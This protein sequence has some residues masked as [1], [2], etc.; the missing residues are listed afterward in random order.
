MGG[1]FGG[2]K[3]Q[4]S[5]PTR[6]NAMQ[7]NQSAY[8]NVVP[9]L[10][11]TDRLQITLIDYQDFNSKAT[12]SQSSSGKGGSGQTTSGYTYSASWVGLLC[13]GPVTGILQVYADQTQ[14]TLAT[15]PGGPL[16]LF[17][18]TSGQAPWSYMTTNHPTHAQ[19]YDGKAYIAAPN[20]SLGSGA[21]MPN[22]TFEVQGLKLYNGGPDA[23]PF[24]IN[25][26]Y[27]TDPNHGV[28]FPYLDIP[29]MQAANGWRDYC[30]AMGFL[31]S[32]SET[33]Q[34]SAASFIGEL[35]QATNS[36][37]VW[38][39]GIGL[40]IVPYGD[41]V[42][43]GNGVTY[44]PNLTPEFA[45]IDDDYCPASGS[46][47][48]QVSITPANQTYNI[49][50]VEFL[51]RT[52]QYNT[53]IETY[54]DEQDIA[55]NG[56]RI[57]PT[58]NLHCIKI[59]AIAAVVAALA[60][61]RNLYI[62][63]IYTFTVRMDY[64]LLEPMDFVSITETQTGIKNKLLR[65]TETTDN[66]DDSFTIVAEEMLV[67]PAHA[68]IY[69]TQFAAGYAANYGA[70]PGNVDVPY[71][72]TF[73]PLLASPGSGGY[74]LGIAVGGTSGMWGG[75]DIYASLDNVTYQR[76]GSNTFAAQYG[77]L[78]GPI[79]SAPDPDTV[80]VLSVQLNSTIQDPLVSLSRA[81]ADNLR[82]PML[83]DG[84]IMSYQTATPLGNDAFKLNYLRR[85][86]YGSANTSHTSSGQFA[87][88]NDGIFRLPFDPGLVGQP[89]WFKFQ[90]YNLFGGGVQDLSTL[91]AYAATFQGQNGGQ[92]T[93]PGATPLIARGQCVIQGNSIYKQPGSASQWDSDCYSKDAFAGGCSMRFQSCQLGNTGYSLMIGLNSDPLTDQNYTSLDHAWYINNTDAKAYIYRN[94][95]FIQSTTTFTTDTVFEIRYDGKFVK[96]YQDSVLWYTVAD[97]NK[98]FFLDSSFYTPGAAVQN[99]FFGSLNPANSTP[100]IT[101]GGCTV[102]DESATKSGGVDA[103]Y[104]SDMYSLEGYPTMHFSCKA[105]QTNAFMMI[106]ITE[107]PGG[108]QTYND[109]KW[110]WYFTSSGTCQELIRPS[111]GGNPVLIGTPVAYDKTTVFGVTYDGTTISPTINGVVVDPHA[112]FSTSNQVYFLHVVFFN[113]G[114]G[115]NTLQYG[116]STSN[117]IADTAQ[118]GANS[119]SGL[120]GVTSTSGGSGTILTSSGTSFAQTFVAGSTA[121]NWGSPYGIDMQVD[122]QFRA[123]TGSPTATTLGLSAMSLQMMRDGGAG[124]ATYVP[125]GAP[126]D[127][128]AVL[129]GVAMTQVAGQGCYAARQLVTLST[130]DVLPAHPVGYTYG[131]FINWTASGTAGVVA[132]DWIVA[133]N[134]CKIREYKR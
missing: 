70:D 79:T 44:T 15:A 96:Y 41:Q 105:N 49:W 24:D 30:T 110:G 115:F 52:N 47:P 74:E 111:T 28:G 118:L 53:A 81:D 25:V 1:L 82:Q 69:N 80:N 11:G 6:F 48:I 90:S 107:S 59:R 83:V 33:T 2:K 8:G 64:S 117:Q 55:I 75:C 66:P 95:N 63:A 40:R 126:F 103:V 29:G 127:L 20:Y 21:A 65:I 56:P 43:T 102:S 19:S 26:D 61:Q 119:A 125:V 13:S 78:T 57:A 71:I 16:T 133:A 50:N 68:P 101:R 88:L 98:V 86:Q 132:G 134:V 129:Q 14:C 109:F 3:T 87:M 89:V 36:N 32:P 45:F 39:A 76:A 104:D 84:E 10:Y 67:G 131:L 23:H 93:S 73:P 38:S 122:I 116:P 27:C 91:T 9:L 108:V 18:G 54:R 60:A 22:L 94:G 121:S 123:F 4:S 7:I 85:G 100:Y 34:R 113:K 12:T 114:A 97:P 124:G 51:D 106:G 128:H 58:V 99:V 72:F 130:L 92:L 112:D 5:I 77:K 31:L 46:A 35:V 42:V 62:R 37:T 17:K 120:V